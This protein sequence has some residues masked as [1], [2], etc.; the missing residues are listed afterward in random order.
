MILKNRILKQI[1][2]L[3]I[4]S[5]FCVNYINAEEEDEVKTVAS[6]IEKINKDLKTL[7]KAVYSSAEVKT[8]ISYT[9]KFK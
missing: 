6:Q 4:I 5:F 8:K 3:L 1:I 7:E 2:C 9:R